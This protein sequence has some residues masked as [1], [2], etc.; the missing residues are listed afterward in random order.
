MILC[1]NHAASWVVSE[2]EK[3][4]HNMLHTKN[5]VLKTRVAEVIRKVTQQF[6]SKEDADYLE[7]LEECLGK[8]AV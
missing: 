4:T 8:L 7:K 6:N 5:S 3:L 1:K 2:L